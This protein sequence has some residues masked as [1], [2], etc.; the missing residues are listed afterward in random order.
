MSE[1]C[2]IFVK[3]VHAGG[4]GHRACTY[5]GTHCHVGVFAMHS[6]E[7]P[8]PPYFTP[9]FTPDE[10]IIGLETLE[11]RPLCC[12]HVELGHCPWP[13]DLSN[14]NTPTCCINMAQACARP[15]LGSAWSN[16]EPLLVPNSLTLGSAQVL[17]RR[18]AV[19]PAKH[20][21]PQ[22]CRRHVAAAAGGDNDAGVP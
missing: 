1:C 9:D 22:Q 13:A 11:K 10:T 19:C 16:R 12:L 2:C 8:L 6:P 20:R 14:R 17:H 7:R 3:S 15:A 21:T 4:I 18:S 5:R